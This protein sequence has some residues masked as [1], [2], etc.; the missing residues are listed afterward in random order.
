MS[1]KYWLR[2]LVQKK[3]K[4]ASKTRTCDARLRAHAYTHRYCDFCI[5]TFSFFLIFFAITCFII[6]QRM[7]G[8]KR[9]RAL[10]KETEPSAN[11]SPTKKRRVS[12]KV[13][14]L[15]KRKKAYA[16]S[17]SQSRKISSNDPTRKLIKRF[18]QPEGENEKKMKLV[19]G[20][21]R[22]LMDVVEQQMWDLIQKCAVFAHDDHKQNDKQKQNGK[23]NGALIQC[24]HVMGTVALRQRIV[25]IEIPKNWN[26][27]KWEDSVVKKGQIK[28]LIDAAFTGSSDDAKLM[29]AAYMTEIV[30]TYSMT[31]SQLT[32]N[33]KRVTVTSDDLMLA[34]TRHSCNN[35]FN[36]DKVWT[37]D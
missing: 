20:A 13:A 27:F 7:V 3:I 31:A 11:G 6:L 37:R 35:V 23:Q 26:E 32:K 29:L 25:A 5:R 9:V 30:R 17:Q 28:K 24:R 22:K 21:E 14:T 15:R 18:I 2:E 1:K 12:R 8:S 34:V 16:A 10:V 33:K 4:F 36:G 19:K